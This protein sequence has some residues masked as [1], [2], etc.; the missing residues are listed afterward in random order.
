MSL[1]N[2]FRT[3]V[4]VCVRSFLVVLDIKFVTRIGNNRVDIVYASAGGVIL[5][6][7]DRTVV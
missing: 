3:V 5:T 2:S 4:V 1:D 7:M 6:N